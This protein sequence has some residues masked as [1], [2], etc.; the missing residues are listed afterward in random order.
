M[1]PNATLRELIEAA[2][3]GDWESMLEAANDLAEWIDKGGFPPADPR[4]KEG[5]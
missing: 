1:D 5:S 4:K 3:R 2:V